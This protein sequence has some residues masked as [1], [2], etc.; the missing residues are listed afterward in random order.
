MGKRLDLKQFIEICK[1]KHDGDGKY[2]YSKIK[3]YIN[4]KTYYT[5]RCI[6]HDYTFDIRGDMHL[7]G[8]GCRKCK[9]NKLSNLRKNSLDDVIEF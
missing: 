9:K 6:E 8:Q 2:D 5:I 4:N 3:E 7:Q 1:L